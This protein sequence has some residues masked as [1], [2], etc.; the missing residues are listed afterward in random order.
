[1]SEPQGG[2]AT[3]RA[4]IDALALLTDKLSIHPEIVAGRVRYEAN[5]YKLLNRLKGGE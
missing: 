4:Q 5:N 2:V 3:S 1:M